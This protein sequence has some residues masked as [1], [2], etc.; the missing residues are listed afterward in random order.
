MKPLP[1]APVFSW[2]GSPANVVL[3]KT[4]GCETK[5]QGRRALG[6]GAEQNQPQSSG[7]AVGFPVGALSFLQRQW[8]W[9]KPQLRKELK[10]CWAGCSCAVSWGKDACLCL[11][12]LDCKTSSLQ[13]GLAGMPKVQPSHL[14]HFPPYHVKQDFWNCQRGVFFLLYL[15]FIW[16]CLCK[17]RPVGLITFSK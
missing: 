14:P 2:E 11:W 1:G 8:L 10:W 15:G 3:L 4:V 6:A 12:L 13:A 7:C 5:A 17:K 9:G 16:W